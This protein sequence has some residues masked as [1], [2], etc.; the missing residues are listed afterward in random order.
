LKQHRFET[1]VVFW[2]LVCGFI[3]DGGE[4]PEAGLLDDRRRTWEYVKTNLESERREGMREDMMSEI[5][6]MS[7]G[8]EEESE[9]AETFL[10]R[11]SRS[12]A[13]A[14][15]GPMLQARFNNRCLRTSR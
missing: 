14:E 4:P 8:K 10:R 1:V 5:D 7:I 3:H 9:D 15:Y 2:Q 6:E 13:C 12:T 11:P